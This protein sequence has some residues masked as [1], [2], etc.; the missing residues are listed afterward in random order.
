MTPKS[1]VGG[2]ACAEMQA[3]LALYYYGDLS[4][5]DRARVADHLATCVPCAAFIEDLK[6][7]LPLTATADEPPTEFWLDYTRELR[8]KITATEERFFSRQNFLAFFPGWRLPALATAAIL[9]LAL[10]LIFNRNSGERNLPYA[11]DEAALLAVLPIAENLDFFRAM[12]FLDSMELLDAE[13]RRSQ[14]AA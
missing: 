6:S 4:A 1:N 9:V 8:Q 12:E 11:P 14:G 7:I 10:T 2:K 5:A 3:D 13:G